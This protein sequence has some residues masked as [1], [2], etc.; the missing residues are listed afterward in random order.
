MQ[1]AALERELSEAHAEEVHRL[2][3]QLTLAEKQTEEHEVLYLRYIHIECYPVLYDLLQRLFQS[4]E[5]EVNCLVTKMGLKPG[6][7]VQY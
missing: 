6:T 5:D 4:V 3:T 1:A 7:E 2:L